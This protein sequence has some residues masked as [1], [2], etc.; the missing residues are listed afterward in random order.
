MAT[1]GAGSLGIITQQDVPVPMRDGTVLRATVC[2]PD[3]PDRY[4]GLL[5]R[6]PYGKGGSCDA[7]MVRS[8]YVVVSQDLRGR[9]ASDGQFT[10]FSSAQTLDGQDG[11]DT[12]E[13]LA[14]QP[15][16][17]GKV[18]TFGTSY[19]AWVQWEAAALR[20]PHLLAMAAFS[21]PTEITDLDYPGTLRLG[22]RL[23]WWLTAIAPDL[24]RRAGLPG[25]HTPAEAREL[26]KLPGGWHWL[27]ELPVAAVVDALPPPLAEE[28]RRWLQR[29]GEPCWRF[30]EK[31]R[32]VTVPNLDCTG[33]FDHCC[34]LGHLVSMQRNG[35]S[36]LAREQSKI[37]VGPWSHAGLGQRQYGEIDFGPQAQVDMTQMTITWFDHR[38]KGLDNGVEDWSACRYFAMGSRTWKS[39][40]AW[41]PAATEHT[42]YLHSEGAANPVEAGGALSAELPGSQ[43]PDE[44]TYDP[45]D[46]VPS[47]WSADM[48][49]TATDRRKLEHR[50][51][52]LYYRTVPLTEDLEIAGHPEVVVWAASSAPDTDFFARLVDE[53]PGGPALE[54]CYGFVRA[55]YRHGLQAEEL[56]TP[57]QVTKL[58]LVMGPTAVRFAAGHRIRLEIT[59]SDFPNFDRNHNTGG[60]DLFEVTL[61]PARQAVHHSA[62]HPSSLILPVCEGSPVTDANPTAA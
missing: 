42:L 44:Y 56:L 4:P 6:T 12:I 18:G 32:E 11:Y 45:R 35:G 62:A 50:G 19:P 47:L 33:W 20:P 31:H 59:S 29:P 15:F 5:H 40:A 7:N 52:I 8:G 58:R 60:A 49:T 61:Q 26:A 21:I 37:V 22:R 10:S 39:A 48:F 23:S 16:C 54:V 57:G 28:A 1:T 14:A 25:P 3:G 36:D 46:P 55:R 13:W 41:P 43:P 9:Y 24:R 51:D 38:L 17:N 2:R 30:T 27:S 34:S 53:D